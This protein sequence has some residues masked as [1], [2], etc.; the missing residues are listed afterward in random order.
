MSIRK[1]IDWAIQDAQTTQ[2]GTIAS[3][4]YQYQ[5]A[6][7]SWVWACDVDIG[8]DEVL[9]CVPVAANNR[10]I[11]YAEQGKGVC[12]SRLGSGKWSITGLSKTLNST[13]HYIFVTFTDD[14]AQI[15]GSRMVGNINR[16]LTYGELGTLAAPYGYG[17][18]PYGMQGKFDYEGNLIEILES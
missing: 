4:F 17:V 11:I 10:D 16:P 9:R 8:E 12:L 6:A 13:V 18:L 14:M 5:D 15:T 1:I 2:T 3:E 7:G